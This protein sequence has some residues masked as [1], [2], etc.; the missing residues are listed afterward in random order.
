MAWS[1]KQRGATTGYYY[2]S[3]RVNGRSVKVYFGRGITA[4]LAAHLDE[5]ARQDRRAEREVQLAEQ[6][7]L[8]VADLAF[9]DARA[10]VYLLVQAV[11]ILSGFHMHRGSDWRRRRHG[12]ATPGR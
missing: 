10:L 11:L 5:C 7:R 3:K 2:R 4:R 9:A 1:R 6:V 8:S 12:H